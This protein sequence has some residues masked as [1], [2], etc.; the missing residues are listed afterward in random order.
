[1]Y[2][3]LKVL[4]VAAVVL[5]LG[6]IVTG[7]LWKVHADQTKDPVIIR[8]TVAGLI[9]ADRWFTIPGVVLIVISGV[10]AAIIGGLPLLGT[11]WI[12]WGII[13]FTISGI[14]YM[15]RVVPLQRQMLNVARSG[16]ET[17]NFDW[18][19]YHSLSRGWNLWGTIALLAPALAMIAMI[20]KPS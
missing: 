19:K 11:R 13:L 3:A 7:L 4:H 15:A 5:F 18:D 6:N 10:A 14:A 12:L 1:M 8:H 17:G 9:R 20:A 16:A 2:I